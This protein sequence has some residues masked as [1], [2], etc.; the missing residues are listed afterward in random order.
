MP[1][2][3]T[4]PES[5]VHQSGLLPRQWLDSDGDILA[6]YDDDSACEAGYARLLTTGWPVTDLK[7]ARFDGEASFVV[8]MPRPMGDRQYVRCLDLWEGRLHDRLAYGL[9]VLQPGQWVRTHPG[10]RPSRWVGAKRS[11]TLWAAHWSGGTRHQDEQFRAMCA[12][13]RGSLT[14]FHTTRRS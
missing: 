13:R 2:T 5:L 10:S 12:T 11:G 8:L 14:E 9:A 6:V 3:P 1:E 4:L 7:L